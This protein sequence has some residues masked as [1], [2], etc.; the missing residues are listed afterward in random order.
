M[1]FF[2]TS[3]T[4]T[5]YELF[6]VVVHKGTCY[7]GH[8]YGYIKDID[9]IGTWKRPPPPSASVCEELLILSTCWSLELPFF[10]NSPIIKCGY[11][12]DSVYSELPLEREQSCTF[13]TFFGTIA[14]F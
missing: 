8:Y 13:R 3:V 7:L 9:R 4:E 10:Q 6:A 12:F 2:Q 5:N 1:K 11:F 14:N